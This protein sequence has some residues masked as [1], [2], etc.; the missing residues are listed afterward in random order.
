MEREY[1]L[2]LPA[3]MHSE[4]A[5]IIQ[6]ISVEPE[7]RLQHQLYGMPSTL[8]TFA[9]VRLTPLLIAK[10]GQNGGYE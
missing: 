8:N 10:I 6:D 7:S 2:T 9:L 3:G 1:G 4:F 5:R